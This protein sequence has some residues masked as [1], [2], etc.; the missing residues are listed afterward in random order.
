MRN[1]S[2]VRPGSIT[3]EPSIVR[4]LQTSPANFTR[5]PW[6]STRSSVTASRPISVSTPVRNSWGV[7]RW[8]RAIGR[9]TAS[10]AMATPEATRTWTR[11]GVPTAA[12]TD[13]ARAPAASMRKTR[14]S[15]A[16]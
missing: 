15:V 16:S 5:P 3:S 7:F 9:T 13:P 12:A 1:T 11:N 4:A 10:M 14:S 6:M 8:R 2:T